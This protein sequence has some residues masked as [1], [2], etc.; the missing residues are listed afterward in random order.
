LVFFWGPL[1]P[2]HKKET[3]KNPSKEKRRIQTKKKFYRE[4]LKVLKWDRK[5]GYPV[6][7]VV[8]RETIPLL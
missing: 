6:Q 7:G 4:K 1:P 8:T 2:T 3:Q 5:R